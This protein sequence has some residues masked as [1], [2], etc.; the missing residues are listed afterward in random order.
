MVESIQKK[1][2]QCF[3]TPGMIVANSD[4]YFDD[5]RQRVDEPPVRLLGI[6][7][8]CFVYYGWLH[9]FVTQEIKKDEDLGWGYSRACKDFKPFIIRTVNEGKKELLFIAV[10][11]YGRRLLVQSIARNFL[12]FSSQETAIAWMEMNPLA[13]HEQF[14]SNEFPV[15]FTFESCN[16]LLYRVFVM[17]HSSTKTRILELKVS[18]D[19]NKNFIPFITK[20]VLDVDPLVHAPIYGSTFIASHDFKVGNTTE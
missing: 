18:I 19:K 2:Q 5:A 14:L 12:R 6:T 17:G 1:V 20:V 16:N 3:K 8:D 7:A 15:D 11:R 10:K 13:R 4:D 9:Q